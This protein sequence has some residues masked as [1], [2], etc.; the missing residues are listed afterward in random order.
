MTEVEATSSTMDTEINV[1]VGEVKEAKVKKSKKS[2]GDKKTKEKKGK[3]EEVE[4]EEKGKKRK[5]AEEKEEKKSKKKAKT[6]EVS[7]AEVVAPGPEDF[8]HYRIS[9]ESIEILN[10]KGIISLFPIQQQSFNPIY[11][12]KDVVGRACTGTGKT[13]S[14]ALP[15]VEKLML[16]KPSGRGRKP[17]VLVM[18][19][20]R[21]LAR[22]V[23]G[24]FEMIGP[25][26]SVICIYG[27]VPYESQE[28]AFRDGVDIV[29]GTPG[30][31]V[32]HLER[33]N[34][35]LSCMRFVVM[36][37]ADQMLDI[38]FKDAMETILCNICPN[39]KAESKHQLLL[40]SATLPGWVNE[41]V[42]KYCRDD[43][44]II[45]LVKDQK[46]KT[47]AT[48]EHMAIRCHWQ[49][50]G[51]ALR[52]V[53]TVYAG[54]H[55]RTIVFV[56]TKREANDL[57]LTAVMNTE[58][59]VLHGDIAQKQRE[60]TLQ[61]FRDG[62][63]RCLIATDVAARGLDIP[64]V[65]VVINCE[66]PKDVDTYVHR[67]GRTGRAGKKGVC[68]SFYTPKQEDF[69]RV[70]EKRTGMALKRIG[71]PQPHQLMVAIGEDSKKSLEKV[72]ADILPHFES[73]AQELIDSKGA[74]ASL[75]AALAHIS[76]YTEMK[77]RSL[78][79]SSEG[80]ETYMIEVDQE[81]RGTGYFWGII[82]RNLG[83]DIK[84]E[85]KGMRM[86]VDQKGCLFDV[87][88]EMCAKV[89][90]LWK[91][92]RNC[93]LTQPVDLPELVEPTYSQM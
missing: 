25:Q 72:P 31:L 18:A 90:E 37:E 56:E 15:I 78:L 82:E 13:L 87:P 22:Q 17:L 44:V 58:C 77:K 21:E 79:N 40:F 39:G 38:G 36:D 30:R 70:I 4:K 65:D 23:S 59:Q 28:R 83:E 51:S 42:R 50:R 68:I 45:D 9:K 2:S 27:G 52:D 47:S 10:K 6:E 35:D 88:L 55:G 93:T 85:I 33:G 66:P 92:Q 91:D 1:V 61:G 63:F 81:V 71:P 73:L 64:E 34:M 62:T 69:L 43:K 5:S 20:T 41:V 48:I 29:V 84:A 75:C 24:D 7:D 54:K 16:D 60:T 74:L 19:P 8:S 89:K 11:D 57:A 3:K 12:G 26:L 53:V 80:Y 14:F 46:N 32:D 86:R 67:S 76:G 49:Q